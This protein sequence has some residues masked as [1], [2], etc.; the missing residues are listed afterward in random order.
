MYFRLSKIHPILGLE[1]AGRILYEFAYHQLGDSGNAGMYYYSYFPMKFIQPVAYFALIRQVSW[2]ATCRVSDRHIFH[3]YFCRNGVNRGQNLKIYGNTS[4]NR[5]S[6]SKSTRSKNI[7]NQ[8]SKKIN[9]LFVDPLALL[10]V[11]L[12]SS[13]RPEFTYVIFSHRIKY[14]WKYTRKGAKFCW[15]LIWDTIAVLNLVGCIR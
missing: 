1:A 3:E 2:R 7:R 8:H 5:Q 9:F 13:R 10:R 11:F 4:Q 15:I 6:H 12:N 14:W